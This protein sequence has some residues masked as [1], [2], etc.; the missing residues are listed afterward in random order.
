LLVAGFGIQEK[1]ACWTWAA[2]RLCGCVS[3]L[4]CISMLSGLCFCGD[5][6]FGMDQRYVLLARVGDTVML[7]VS[8]WLPTEQVMLWF[9]LLKVQN[10][11]QHPPLVADGG[12][13]TV[14][15]GGSTTRSGI[16]KPGG[17]RASIIGTFLG[18]G[19]ESRSRQA[20]VRVLSTSS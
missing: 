19:V 6:V 1:E 9:S 2:G 5:L 7:D 13:R 16:G 18:S 17:R 14:G 15:G 20:G 12:S 10:W 4:V 8:M 11:I 3:G